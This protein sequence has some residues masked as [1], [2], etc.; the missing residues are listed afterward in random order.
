MRWAISVIVVF[1]VGSL[2]AP[3]AH[4]I[5]FLPAI[6]LIPIAKIIAFIIGG[7]SFPALG[8]GALWSKLFGKSLGRT[9]SAII[10][11]LMVLAIILAIF[12]K[13]H[14]PDRPLF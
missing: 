3:Q 2:F 8:V 1:I 12:F 13:L 11:I 7:F 9:I 14:N 5:V 10:A 4:A 6:V